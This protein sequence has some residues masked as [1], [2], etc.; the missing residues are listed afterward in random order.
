MGPLSGDLRKRVVSAVCEEGMSC[1]GSARRFG[2]SFSSAIRWVAALHERG[3]YA[4][5]RMG[6]DTRSQR[7]EAHADFLLGLHRREPDLT[8]NEICDRLSRARGER[9]SPSM[10]WRFFDRHDI[11]FKK[12]PRTRAS[13]TARTSL[14]G[15][16]DGSTVN[17][18]SIR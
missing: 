15:G 2:V 8:L 1:R 3:S 7:V 10:I 11:T 17:S 13:R 5:L 18:T 16:G 9:V 12:N 14:S 4:P 6:G